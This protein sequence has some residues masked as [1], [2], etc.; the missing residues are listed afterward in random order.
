MVDLK[1]NVNISEDFVD[2]VDGYVA[3]FKIGNL[4]NT[5][6]W[7]AH[8]YYAYMQKYAVVDYYA[9]S[10]WLAWTYSSAGA[11]GT[12]LTNM[13]GFEVRVGYAFGPKFSLMLHVYTAK[14]IK[15]E[16]QVKENGNRLRLNLSVG[17]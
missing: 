17:L 14:Q 8:I 4:E 7:V 2:Q 10:D 15:A 3:N 6:D 5:G 9:Q 16:Q 13:Q 1:K 11:T 12:R